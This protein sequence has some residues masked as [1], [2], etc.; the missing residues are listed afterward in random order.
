MTINDASITL[1][2]KLEVLNK[3]LLNE[4]LLSKTTNTI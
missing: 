1:Q 3:T 2:D 4:S